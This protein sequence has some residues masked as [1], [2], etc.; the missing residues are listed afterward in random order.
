M[1]LAPSLSF[2][3]KHAAGIFFT[4]CSKIA[5]RRSNSPPRTLWVHKKT[6]V[7]QGVPSPPLCTLMMPR[8][9]YVA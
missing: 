8:I 7:R 5:N 6:T 3:K 4:V 2:A 9:V 1:Q